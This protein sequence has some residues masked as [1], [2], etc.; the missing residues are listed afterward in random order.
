MTTRKELEN[1]F[2]RWAHMAGFA[3]ERTATQREVVWLEHRQS[4]TYG[5][6][7]YRVKVIGEHGGERTMVFGSEYLSAS[8]MKAALSFAC[9]T[10][11]AQTRR[12]QLR[13]KVGG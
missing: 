3:T 11:E 13:T 6:K 10:L 2:A 1:L 8:E 9:R 7:T 5:S 4:G 12:P